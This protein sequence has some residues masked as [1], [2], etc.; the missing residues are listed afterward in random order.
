MTDSTRD[1]Y[2]SNAHTYAASGT[3][4]PR[5]ATFLNRCTPGGEILELGTGSGRDARAMICAGFRVDATDGS[6]Q[7]AAIAEHHIRQPVRVM[8]FQELAAKRAYDGIYASASLLHVPRQELGGVITRVHTALRH[9]GVVWASFKSGAA[10]SLDALGRHY[11]YLSAP[12]LSAVWHAGGDWS[13]LSTESWQGS[14]FDK[15]PTEW[16]AVTAVRRE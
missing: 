15:Q 9:N 6:S 13:E 5:L 14:A 12:E 1:F 3:I 7:L 4:N 10:E 11:N 16:V 8:Q 2:N